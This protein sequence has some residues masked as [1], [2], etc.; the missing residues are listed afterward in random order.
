MFGTSLKR[1]LNISG[2][3]EYRRHYPG[4]PG[5]KIPLDGKIIEGE[6]MLDTLPSPANPSPEK[7]PLETTYFPAVSTR[8][9]Y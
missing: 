6:A 7:P 1:A 2:N 8:T 4:K 3:G 5:E 9:A